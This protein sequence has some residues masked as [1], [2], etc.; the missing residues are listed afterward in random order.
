MLHKIN[1]TSE[2]KPGN[3]TFSVRIPVSQKG[4]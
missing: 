4:E 3:T 2:S 1:F